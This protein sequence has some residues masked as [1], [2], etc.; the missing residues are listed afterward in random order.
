MQRH[1]NCFDQKMSVSQIQQ[2]CNKSNQQ[3]HQKQ[4]KNRSIY[5]NGIHAFLK[6]ACSNVERAI[7]SFRLWC[8]INDKK[9]LTFSTEKFLKVKENMEKKMNTK[10]SFCDLIEKQICHRFES[11]HIFY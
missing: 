8:G 6:L 7:R 3:S 1:I 4:G 11:K 2:I 9:M 5:Y 10:M